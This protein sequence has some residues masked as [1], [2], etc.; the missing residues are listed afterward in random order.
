MSTAQ[1][2]PHNQPIPPPHQ[3]KKGLGTGAKIAIG[4]VAG[5]IGLAILAVIGFFLLFEYANNQDYE[6]ATEECEAKVLE[7]AKYPGGVTFV[8][9]IEVETEEDRFESSRLFRAS[10]EVDFPNAFGV[11]KRGVYSCTVYVN[12]GYIDSSSAFVLGIEE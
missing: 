7:W 9:P 11:P 8:D 3:E 12:T 6:A 5:I 10:G 4:I 2:H 1:P